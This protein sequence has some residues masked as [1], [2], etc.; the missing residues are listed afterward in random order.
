M[1]TTVQNVIDLAKV[2]YPSL[3]DFGD[4]VAVKLFNEVHNEILTR[5]GVQTDTE[6]ITLVADQRE[7]ALNVTARFASTAVYVRS[8]TEG[9]ATKLEPVSQETLERQS[10]GYQFEDSG[11]P[12][13]Y[14][15]THSNDGTVKIGFDPAPD[16]SSTGGYPSVVLRV[17]RGATLTAAGNLPLGVKNFQAWIIGIQAYWCRSRS[18]PEANEKMAE[19]ERELGLLQAWRHNFMAENPST[20]VPA[21]SGRRLTRV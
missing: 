20:I 9:D 3:P 11:E 13:R 4:S 6:T 15:I 8:A 12:S 14:Y 10:G 18:L 16:T 17:G 1:P 19:F 2:G 5:V 21:R 7:Y